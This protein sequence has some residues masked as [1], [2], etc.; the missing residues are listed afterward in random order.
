[1]ARLSSEKGAKLEDAL[2]TIFQRNPSVN[3]TE[4]L[5]QVVETYPDLREDVSVRDLNYPYQS[6]AGRGASR[7][8]AAAG[9]ADPEQR[10]RHRQRTRLREPI[11]S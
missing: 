8:V 10:R 6:S 1:M 3:Y 9:D 2:V 4:A 5:E 7:E 11:R